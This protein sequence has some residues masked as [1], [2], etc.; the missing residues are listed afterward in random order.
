M[1]HPRAAF[2]LQSTLRWGRGVIDEI[3]LEA[4]RFGQRA[5]ILISASAEREGVLLQLLQNL[6]VTGVVS[7]SLTISGEP[8]IEN[9]CGAL[10]KAKNF[11]SDLVLGV[12]G[13]SAMD[14]AKAVAGLYFLEGDPKE[15]FLGRT[16]LCKGLPLITIPTVP[17]S[18][19]EVTPNAVL[20][21]KESILKQ[22]VR[23]PDWVASTV[24]IDPALSMGV[25]R[26]R[27]LYSGLD[28]LCQAIEAFT[29]MGA[30][31]VTDIYARDAAQRFAVDLPKVMETPDN[32]EARESLS[33]ASFEG[34]IALAAARLGAVHGL[35]HPLG[36]RYH[37]PHGLVCA[38]LLPMV[39]RFNL[40][41]AYPKYAMLGRDLGLQEKGMD[42]YDQ[43]V[44]Y[45]RYIMNLQ[46]QWGIP[47]RLRQLGV[48]RDDFNVIIEESL[49]SGSLKANPRPAHSSDLMALL[50][51]NW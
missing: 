17:G 4:S 3:G 36:A 34:G 42:T 41:E 11:A 49:P 44:Q 13:G 40:P 45:V 20:T 14:L 15:A 12:G 7:D 25:P 9:L 35:A 47:Q 6:M 37:V 46:K 51:E 24:L 27:L 50:Q 1:N 48:L 39:M 23:H 19:A 8:T 21:D 31:A 33:I 43:A 32:L 16:P 30:N 5:F 38:T 22:S 18:G 28:G 26:E 10:N 2:S 29:S